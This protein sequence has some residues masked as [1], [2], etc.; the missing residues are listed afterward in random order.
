MTEHSITKRI[1]LAAQPGIK[2]P[3]R[4]AEFSA[5]AI[6]TAIDMVYCQ[7]GRFRYATASAFAPIVSN[8]VKSDFV[9]SD[10]F[11][12]AIDLSSIA[13]VFIKPILRFLFSD[14]G[15]CSV[16]STSPQAIIALTTHPFAQLW[17]TIPAFTTYTWRSFSRHIIPPY[18]VYYTTYLMGA[19]YD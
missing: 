5:M 18:Y 9:H 15:V 13:R 16:S 12:L 14:L 11:R 19:Q 2:L 6:T 8:N 7:E 10:K 17:G 4:I 3:T 1:M